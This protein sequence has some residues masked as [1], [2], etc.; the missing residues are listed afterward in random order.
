MALIMALERLE[1]RGGE[2]SGEETEGKTPPPLFSSRAGSSRDGK[3]QPASLPT[4]GVSL[5]DEVPS[6]QWGT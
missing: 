6:A 5:K 2:G 4:C 3:G 1:G